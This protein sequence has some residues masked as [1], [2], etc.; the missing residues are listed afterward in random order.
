[1]AGCRYNMRDASLRPRK[2][3]PGPSSLRSRNGTSPSAAIPIPDPEPASKP[4]V[5]DLD[6]LGTKPDQEEGAHAPA[7]DDAE[8]GR[9]AGR[10]IATEADV[11]P[12]GEM[13]GGAAGQ[14]SGDV[15]PTDGEGIGNSQRHGEE[16]HRR[17]HSTD[18][19]APANSYRTSF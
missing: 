11:S 1:M 15:H 16:I 17:R 9:V 3:L 12:A 19:S 7:I 18:A 8:V 14:A 2:R 5:A 6:L 13:E 4:S 10:R